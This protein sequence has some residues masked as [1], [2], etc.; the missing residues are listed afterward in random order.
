MKENK[1]AV[2]GRG[3]AMQHI[4]G[5]SSNTADVCFDLEKGG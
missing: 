5:L 4:H 2:C 1:K 3:N